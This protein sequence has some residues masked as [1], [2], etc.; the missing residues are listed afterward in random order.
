[1]WLYQIDLIKSNGITLFF[2]C[3][4]LV[5]KRALTGSFT[6]SRFGC[7]CFCFSV[8][9]CM[10][11][12]FQLGFHFE[13]DA[14]LSSNALKS[15]FFRFWHW[16]GPKWVKIGKMLPSYLAIICTLIIHW[17]YFSFLDYDFWFNNQQ[18]FLCCCF[19]NNKAC[20]LLR[21]HFCVW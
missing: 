1:M 4:D 17:T 6:K 5:N 13:K 18:V 3:F 10:G 19:I 2:Y 20:R 15:G 8:A 11:R 9:L 21:R 7:T 14:Y 16:M 12:N